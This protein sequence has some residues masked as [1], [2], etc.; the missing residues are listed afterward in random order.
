MQEFQIRG[1]LRSDGLSQGD[2]RG[3]AEVSEHRYAVRQWRFVGS[4]SAD[5]KGGLMGLQPVVA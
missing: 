5:P 4:A 3:L 1:D 2:V